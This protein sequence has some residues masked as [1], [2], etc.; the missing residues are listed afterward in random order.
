MNHL[1][2]NLLIRFIESK[3]E[4]RRDL[5]SIDIRNKRYTSPNLDVAK[6]LQE[7]LD[8]ARELERDEKAHLALGELPPGWY[9]DPVPG[10]W[11]G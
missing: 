4:W 2:Y 1:N 9:D 7:V 3:L 8:Y 10:N 6:E 5:A 11:S